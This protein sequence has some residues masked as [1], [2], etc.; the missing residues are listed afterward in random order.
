V[1]ED[2]GAPRF[3]KD[4]GLVLS[5]AGAGGAMVAAVWLLLGFR[6][7]NYRDDGMLFPGQQ[8]SQVVPKLL[9]DQ[10]KVAA[11]VVASASCQLLGLVF[12]LI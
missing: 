1:G 7:E 4:A 11:L 5:L 2:H 8:E 12:G 6:P 9:R 3:V 10:G